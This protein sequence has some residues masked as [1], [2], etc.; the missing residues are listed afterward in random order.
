VAAGRFQYQRQDANL[1][2][3]QALEEYRRGYPGLL[4]VG[5]LDQA[6]AALFLAHDL[7]HVVFGLDTKITDEVLADACAVCCTDVG[8]RRY[9]TYLR[10]SPAARAIFR[11]VGG[12]QSAQSLIRALPRVLRVAWRG[13]R[14]KKKWPW[15]RSA[16]Y[17]DVPLSDL[18]EEFGIRVA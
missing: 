14:M 16:A 2:L 10:S 7:C 9:L 12:F 3:R 17:L 5:D 18:R 8:V 15:H 1:T 11:Q 13:W 4:Q 6:S